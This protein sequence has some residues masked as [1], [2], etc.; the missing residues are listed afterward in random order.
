LTQL[1]TPLLCF[2][3]LLLPFPCP[4]PAQVRACCPPG[5]ARV[6]RFSLTGEP[7]RPASLR[8]SRLSVPPSLRNP[9][10]HHLVFCQLFW[11]TT[12]STVLY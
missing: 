7:R 1:A 2:G 6:H 9:K 11:H 8:P 4:T 10:T 3:L 12:G 5:N